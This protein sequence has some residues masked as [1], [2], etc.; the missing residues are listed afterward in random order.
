MNYAHIAA[1]LDKYWEGETSIAEEQ[2]L[3]QYF[4]AGNIDPRLHAFAPLF[5]AIAI[6]KAIAFQG[7][8][9]MQVRSRNLAWRNWTAAASVALILT[10]GGWWILHKPVENQNLVVVPTPTETPVTRINT[11]PD[12]NTMKPVPGL[13]RKPGIHKR[14]KAALAHQETPLTPQE[15]AEAEKAYAEVKA[16]LAL[17]SSKLNKGRTEAAKNLNHLESL[18]KVFKKKKETTG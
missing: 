14:L 8:V 3:K 2:Q 11:L 6:E 1:L 16:A 5:K 15:R 10:A 13:K 9:P 12:T 4:Q 18:D 7:N 17:V